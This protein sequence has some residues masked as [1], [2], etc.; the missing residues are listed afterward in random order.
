[1][2]KLLSAP[3]YVGRGGPPD[4]DEP[5]AVLERPVGRWDALITDETW[6]QV[7]AQRRLASRIPQQASGEFV[8]SG[9]LR[10]ARCGARMQG[11]TRPLASGPRREYC[12]SGA[13]VL[14]TEH[15]EKPCW[16]TVPADPIERDV[17]QTIEG[18]LAAAGKPGLRQGI[19]RDL[20]SLAAIPD[21][22]VVGQQIRDLEAARAKTQDRMH[23]LTTQLADK[24]VDVETYTNSAR[25]FRDDLDAT[26][27]RLDELR[28]VRPQAAA[29]GPIDA[30]LGMCAG[31]ARVLASGDVSAVREVYGHLLADVT[32]M[33]LGRGRYQTD[34]TPTPVGFALLQ[35]AVIALRHERTAQA[36][37]LRIRLVVVGDRASSRHPTL[38]IATLLASQND[39]F[40][41][42]LCPTGT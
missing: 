35:A 26:N 24:V 42:L 10:C 6:R 1:V 4:L 25:R 18:T 11:R 5:E 31:W 30:L 40:S 7:A 17:E 36:E 28:Q 29:I 32:P 3:V 37:R 20:R 34:T 12:C 19:I 2:R 39:V 13:L 14:G 21:A 15:V 23:E 38:T 33:R 41:D 27:R 22:D 16:F 9:L 8:L